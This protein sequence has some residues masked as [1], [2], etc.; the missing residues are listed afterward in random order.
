MRHWM[1]WT[2]LGLM[3]CGGKDDEGTDATDGTTTTEGDADTDA[4]SD[5][6]TDPTQ[7]NGTTTTTTTT[8]TTDPT[9][10]SR[11][12]GCPPAY[13]A[14]PVSYADCAS[15][16][17]TQENGN[18]T[19]EVQSG[20]DAAGNLVYQLSQGPDDGTGRPYLFVDT[21]T[22]DANGYTLTHTNDQRDDGT[23]E[24]SEAYTWTFDAN[25]NPSFLDIATTLLNGNVFHSTVAWTW[26][27]CG[28]FVEHYEQDDDADGAIEYASDTV[29][30][31]DGWVESQDYGA[32]GVVDVTETYYVDAV[33]GQPQYLESESF[34]AQ[35]GP[36]FELTFDAFDANGEL[37]A[38]TGVFQLGQYYGAAYY[39]Y[40]V[41]L[42]YT[43][44]F[45]ANG[46]EAQFIV[47]QSIGGTPR[48]Q[49]QTDTQWVCP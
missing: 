33:T 41:D 24:T 32:D 10:P 40:V 4:D 26:S 8:T 28:D 42:D 38:A 45:D 36:E 5:A 13:Q 14:T 22:Y 15:D 48:Y 27:S 34:A 3:A 7:T 43:W 25:G 47:T 21:Y 9:T 35:S 20:F 19:G 6:D 12:L 23:I 46:R 18:F 17:G 31:V 49:E 39:G 16:A 11:A 37:T 2:T 29:Y 44:A 1:L 30:Y